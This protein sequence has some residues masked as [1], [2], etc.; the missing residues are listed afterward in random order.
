M[1][2]KHLPPDRT[3]KQPSENEAISQDLVLVAN[4]D[5]EAFQRVYASSANKLFAICLAV[6]RDHA[7]AQDA[8]Q[9]AFV[10]IWDR[11][12]GY[13]PARTRPM[14]WMGTIARNT[15]IDFYRSRMRHRHVGEEHL[16]T[17]STEAIAAD[18]RIIAMECEDQVRAEIDALD[19]ESERELK[20]IFFLGL[21]YPEAAKR[22][23]LPLATFKSRV[24]RTVLKIR[25]K[26]ADD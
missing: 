10:K 21:T 4:G 16:D 13:D 11:A 23:G 8:L 17:H 7:E 5:R 2:D 19:I 6:T 24:R 14:A 1:P 15:A 18:D 25:R 9:D 26:L 20:S 22:L 12:A 3:A